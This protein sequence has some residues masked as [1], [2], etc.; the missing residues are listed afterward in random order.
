MARM[1]DEE[2]ER[3]MAALDEKLAAAYDELIAVE[4]EVLHGYEHVIELQRELVA[5]KEAELAAMGIAL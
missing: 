1:T 4:R 3:E 2:F 5:T